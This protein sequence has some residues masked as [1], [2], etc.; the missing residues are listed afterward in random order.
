MSLL[1]GISCRGHSSWNVTPW[2]WN[3]LNQ[4]WRRRR[5]VQQARP[6]LRRPYLLF[7]TY[8]MKGKHS[9]DTLNAY[10][11]L[12]VVRF[13]TYVTTLSRIENKSMLYLNVEA[14]FLSTVTHHFQKKFHIFHVLGWPVVARPSRALVVLYRLLTIFACYVFDFLCLDAVS[15]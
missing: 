13:V 11:T 8:L 2:I 3:S 7:V 1:S 10:C 12:I 9:F 4:V 15:K 5:Y 14:L 6:K